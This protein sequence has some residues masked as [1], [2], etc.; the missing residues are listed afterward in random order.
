MASRRLARHGLTEPS[1]AA[2]SDAVAAM[3][4]AHAQVLSAAELSIGL[5]TATGT[6][7]DVRRALETEHS[8]VKTFG[9][10]GTVHLLPTR[11]LALWTGALGAVPTPR[12]PF[13]DDV[14]LTP[15]QTEQLVA[16]VGVALADAELTVDELT[17]ALAELA[18]PWAVDPV[19]PAFQTLWPRWRQAVSTIANRGVLCF[20]ANRGRKVT[21]TSPQ[22]FVPG[23]VP[24]DADA[25]VR[26]LLRGWLHA[27][28]PATPAQFAQ[29]LNASTRWANELFASLGAEVVQV[30]LD[31]VPTWSLSA[32][33]SAETGSPC[34]VRL[35]P[36]FDAFVVGSHPRASLF[37]GAAATRALTP[38][39]QAG[40]YPVL[41]VDGVV[42]GVWHQ[43]RSGRR[44]DVTVEPLGRLR[45]AQR[46]ELE[47]QVERV[48][49]VLEGTPTLT[50]G[51]VQVGAHA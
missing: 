18:G 9:P 5:R 25:S 36:Y 24:D 42:A 35:L 39:G 2:P 46:R 26:T 45:A 1:A 31:G 15:E 33:S 29:W 11:D 10:R 21:Y 12:S 16:A 23:L 8:L 14:Q 19:M 37:P 43:R 50:L 6:R 51:P 13:A 40:N 44:I 47:A 7:A 32:D 41:L 30:E 49:E 27:Y 17:D 28:G 20:G 34:G 48:G 4:G 3:S 22:R 38:S